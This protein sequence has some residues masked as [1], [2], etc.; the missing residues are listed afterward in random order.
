MKKMF[1]IIAMILVIA[2]V[3]FAAGCA[4]NKMTPLTVTPKT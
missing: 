2:S 1:K 4:E 3:I